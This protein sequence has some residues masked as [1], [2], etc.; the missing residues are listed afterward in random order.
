[1]S[2]SNDRSLRFYREVFDLDHLHYGLWE[3]DEPLTLE[4]LRTAQQR[5]EDRLVALLPDGA[6]SV[7]DVGCGTAALARRLADAG[8]EVEGLSPD[9]NQARC[10]RE[11]LDAPFHH[12]RFERF[13]P[14][15]TYD[16]LVFS[17]SCQYIPVDGF[18]A[19]AR[20]CLAPGGHVLIADYFVRDGA[21]G[22]L[23]KS[24]HNHTAFQAA[25]AEA[26]FSPVGEEDVTDA[27]ARSLELASQL[28]DRALVAGD[29]LT[30]KFR[31]RH[32]WVTGL[33]FRLFRR[34]WERLRE[35][36]VLIDADAF[37]ANKKYL[38]LKYR[39]NDD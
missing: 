32:P 35:E 36:R 19:T 34:K 9:D 16:C 30:E 38:F 22:K 6:R 33:V 23:A 18:L 15:R 17:E 27:A 13:V 25:V 12:C 26:G 14:E 31:T 24:G 3:G 20:Q 37:R 28:A 10:F 4:N 1:M 11:A 29:I 21:E 7:L 39:R 5:Y 8:Y 2:K